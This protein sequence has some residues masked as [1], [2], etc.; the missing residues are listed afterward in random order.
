VLAALDSVALEIAR[1]YE[2]GAV[3][4]TVADSILNTLFA[5][6]AQTGRIPDLTHSIFLAFDAGEYSHQ[7][8]DR[9]VDPELKYTRPLI[10]NIL[11]KAGAA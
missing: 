4:F 6:A 7:G 2:R 10:R 3:N 8:D 9:G 11:S 1:R 5:F